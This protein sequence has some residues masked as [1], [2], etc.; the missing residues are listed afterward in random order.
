MLFLERYVYA[1]FIIYLCKVMYIKTACFKTLEKQKQ[2]V[3]FFFREETLV[4][5]H[6]IFPNQRMKAG[7]LFLER[8]MLESWSQ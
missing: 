6:H 4:H 1:H 5:T 3:F 7:S 8:W 2:V